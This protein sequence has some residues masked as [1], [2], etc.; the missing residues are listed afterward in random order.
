MV[1]PSSQSHASF[2]ADSSVGYP[3]LELIAQYHHRCTTPSFSRPLARFVD[4]GSSHR[5][6]LA[7]EERLAATQTE[8]SLAGSKTII[9]EQCEKDLHFRA[10]KI[11]HRVCVV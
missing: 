6:H 5:V 2:C 10:R 9:A 4:P 3:I 1:R 7:E 8:G 11:V